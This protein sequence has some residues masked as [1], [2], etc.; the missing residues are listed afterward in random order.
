[1]EKAVVFYSKALNFNFNDEDL[2]KRYFSLLFQ[3]S[4]MEEVYRFISDESLLDNETN[5]DRL[6]RVLL[7]LPGTLKTVEKL[8][9]LDVYKNKKGISIKLLWK[10]NQTDKAFNLLNKLSF[11]QL[12]M[13]LNEGFFDFTDFILLCLAADAKELLH[14]FAEINEGSANT[15]HFLLEE[16]GQQ[17]IETSTYLALLKRTICLE[18]FELFERL[19]IQ[20]QF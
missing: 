5:A 12:L 14:S 20:V 16:N 18:Q 8:S 4:S 3:Y 9:R 1:M 7:N 2:I 6:M 11:K 17:K 19:Q 15:I 13:V 10:N